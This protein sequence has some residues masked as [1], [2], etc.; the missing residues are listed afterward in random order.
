MKAFDVIGAIKEDSSEDS[1]SVKRI[2]FKV[3]QKI[4]I[5][6]VINTKVQI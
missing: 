2:L 1:Y 3:E 5:P 4:Q 6:I